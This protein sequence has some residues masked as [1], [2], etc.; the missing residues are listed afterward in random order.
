M[1]TGIAFIV[2]LM[3]FSFSKAQELNKAWTP[4]GYVNIS[5]DLP[6][7]LPKP[8]YIE[9]IPGS[10]AFTDPDGNQMINANESAKIVFQLKNSGQ[11]PG[12]NLEARISEKNSIPGLSLSQS[13]VIGT[14]DPGKTISVEIPVSGTM[15]TIDS[16]ALFS[17]VIN[18]VNGFGTDPVII[19]VPVK[20]FVS[21]MVKIVDYKVT[22]QSGTTIEKRKPFEVQVLV[23]NVGQGKA[24]NINVL[25]PVPDNIFCLTDNASVN[26]GSL[27]P[28]EQKLVEYSFVANNNY[29]LNDIKLNFQLKELFNKYS[30]NKSVLI[31]MNQ[32]VASEKLVV[33]GKVEEAKKI[34]VGSLTS[35]VD[36]NIPFNPLKNE[37]RFALIIGNEN[38]SGNLNAEINVPYAINDATIFKQYAVN[39]MGVPENNVYLSMN[40]TAGEMHRLIDL[41]AKLL[42]KVGPKS[43]LIFYYAGHGLPDES[44]K[45]PYLIPVDVDGSNLTAAIKLSDVCSKFG[46]S[47]A[48]K[49][50]VFLDACFS[51]GGRNQG[52]ITARGVRMVPKEELITGNMVVFSASS[53]EQSALPF[54]RE[55]HGL[56]TYFLLKNLQETS[57]NITYEQLAESIRQGVSISALRENG[58]EQDPVVN[59][60]PTVSDKWKTW[61]IKN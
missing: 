50:T 48:S 2:F 42:E 10:L 24:D 34:E 46:N 4:V 28:G 25:I 18:E 43:E 9:I 57:G 37:N 39:T 23:Q 26:I 47:G 19:E 3:I 53:G 49:I 27:A 61:K 51:G 11:G 36:K 30:E 13:Q 52:L 21:P 45:V 54:I 59:I 20:A 29:S 31:A 8:P 56:F 44:T 60:S 40:T 15:S 41:V 32:Q 38:Y 12:L 16:K 14:L 1:K 7:E 22:S 17:I 35:T 6:K 58:K 33:Q 5:K 55:K